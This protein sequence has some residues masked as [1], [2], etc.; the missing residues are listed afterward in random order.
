MTCPSCMENLAHRSHRSGFRD[1]IA[2]LSQRSPYRCHGCSGRFYVYRHGETSPKLRSREERAVMKLA[3]TYR[4][5]KWKRES[6]A[7]GATLLVLVTILYFL[8]QQH[9]TGE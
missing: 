2:S 3:R 9:I 6:L 8:L 1:W 7:Y 4:W 5:R